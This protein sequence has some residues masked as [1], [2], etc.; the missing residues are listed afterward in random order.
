MKEAPSWRDGPNLLM[1]TYSGAGKAKE[2]VEWLEE[3]AP[4]NPQLYSSLASF[5]ARERRWVDAAGAY[6]QALKQSP[7]SF[8]LRVNLASML[9]NAGT[10]AES[11]RRATCCAKRSG[12][13][14][15]N[16][17]GLTL[18]SQAER[19]T[20]D[21]VA[22]E[23]TARKAV[24]QNAQQRA[25]LLRPRR[26]ARETAE[27]PGGRRRARASRGLVPRHG[28]W[29]LRAR[30][31]A[32]APRVRIPGA[33]SAT[34]KAIGAF[35]DAR[36][37]SPNDPAMTTYL[38]RAQMAARNYTAAA[39]LARAA[40]AQNPNDLRLAMLEATALRR[41]GKID[42]GVAAMEEVFRRQQEE[43]DAYV[44]MSQVYSEANRSAQA[45][46]VLQ[47]AQ[48]KFP[49]RDR[50][51][52]RARCDPRS[53]EEVRRIRSGVPAAHHEGSAERAGAEL[54]RIH[55]CR[56]G[57]ASHR[58]GRLHQ[59]EHWRSTPT[60]ARISIASA[61]RTSRTASSISHSNT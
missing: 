35:E 44:A 57:R 55:A 33:R 30:H 17:R 39:E 37:L 26:S 21:S 46:K 31:A 12:C 47:D 22:A 23:T 58:I 3:S 61:G 60:T 11:A 52:V 7:R 56:T 15:T 14:A 59:A 38:I 20:G 51:L 27:V 4:D 24:A 49:H 32:A 9:M 40:R 19:L 50:H 28:G 8:N 43:P 10:H 5:Y 16:E 45:L 54:P 2:A 34:I 6:E 41:A 18:L 25:R 53:S 36:K 13:D 48:A 42:Q 29:R 1:E